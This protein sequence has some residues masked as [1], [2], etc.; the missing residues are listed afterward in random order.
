[1]VIVM[2]MLL[3]QG[4]IQ[5]FQKPATNVYKCNIV[6]SMFNTKTETKLQIF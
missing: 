4:F 3:L 5:L 2:L 6:A 1:L